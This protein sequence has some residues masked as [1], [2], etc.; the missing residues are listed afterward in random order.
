MITKKDLLEAIEDMPMDAKI[1]IISPETDV[2]YIAEA[3]NVSIKYFNINDPSSIFGVITEVGYY[4]MIVTIEDN[5]SGIAATAIA[6]ANINELA[7]S[8]PLI[9]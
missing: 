5:A 1:C 6:I 3:V 8:E 7:K 2:V 9:T 4:K